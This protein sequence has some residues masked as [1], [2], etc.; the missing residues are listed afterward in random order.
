MNASKPAYFATC[1]VAVIS[2][3]PLTW[4]VLFSLLWRL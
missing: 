4:S 1:F 3:M 2:E